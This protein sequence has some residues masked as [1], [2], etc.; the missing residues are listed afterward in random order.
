RPVTASRTSRGTAIAGRSPVDAG[1][2][3]ASTAHT[4]QSPVT[5]HVYGRNSL[6]SEIDRRD[7]TVVAIPEAA[8][9]SDQ[10]RLLHAMRQ[11]RRS[12]HLGPV[13]VAG[14]Q[15]KDL[16]PPLVRFA[17]DDGL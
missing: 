5:A 3:A 10:H 1:D 2:D 17:G 12:E 4:P 11:D 9:V 16:D 13:A 6:P 7:D 14:E 15:I 8:V